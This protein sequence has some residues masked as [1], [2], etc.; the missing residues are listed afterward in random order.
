MIN[1]CQ[2]WAPGWTLDLHYILP[3][4]VFCSVGKGWKSICFF[5]EYKDIAEHLRTCSLT[6]LEYLE[7]QS[8][9]KEYEAELSSKRIEDLKVHVLLDKHEGVIGVVNSYKGKRRNTNA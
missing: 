8:L 7:A 2:E 3:R 1:D 4:I 5:Y 6:N 9:F